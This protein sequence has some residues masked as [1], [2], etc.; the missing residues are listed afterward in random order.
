MVWESSAMQRCATIALERANGI[1][2]P[3]GISVLRS[4]VRE[5]DNG[6][7]TV[8]CRVEGKH[9]KTSNFHYNMTY[10]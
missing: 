8:R 9:L 7:I 1:C 6:C 3:N 10:F 5:E 2:E 4:G